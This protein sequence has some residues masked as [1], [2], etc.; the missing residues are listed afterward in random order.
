MTPDAL[1]RAWPEGVPS[2]G[3]FALTLDP[4]VAEAPILI[5][6][7][8]AR[9]EAL[10]QAISRGMQVVDP[11]FELR[12]APGGAPDGLFW[13]LDFQMSRPAV[14]AMAYV[15]NGMASIDLDAGGGM[16]TAVDV[17]GATEAHWDTASIWPE[18]GTI[19]PET[20]RN[21][22]LQGAAVYAV[23]PIE[24]H[25]DE[26]LAQAAMTALSVMVEEGCFGHAEQENDLSA[27]IWGTNPDG[28]ERHIGV[29]GYR[30]EPELAR[31]VSALTLILTGQPHPPRV[32]IDSNDPA[33]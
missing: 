7:I 8:T 25:L 33:I 26:A 1:R 19:D 14:D 12:I 13:A 17:Q 15:I 18:I 9:A 4:R 11:D 16:F 28:T 31:A 32:V 23:L 2:V 22:G 30:G 6:I 29:T 10:S 3:R 20:D 24:T 21:E 5:E 27:A